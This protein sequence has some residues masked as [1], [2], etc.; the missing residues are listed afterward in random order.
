MQEDDVGDVPGLT[1]PSSP[2][3]RPRRVCFDAA[4]PDRA[5]RAGTAPAPEREAASRPEADSRLISVAMLYVDNANKVQRATNQ[6]L[7]RAHDCGDLVARRLAAACRVDDEDVTAILPS[8]RRM[9]LELGRRVLAEDE[10]CHALGPPLGQLVWGVAAQRRDARAQRNDPPLT[11]QL[12]G[13]QLHDLVGRGSLR[14]Q[15]G[16]ERILE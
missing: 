14:G 3:L 16:T 7:H 10:R 6:R 9:Y 4:S 12:L 5:A 15:L 11:L 2:T 13:L 8:A 1:A